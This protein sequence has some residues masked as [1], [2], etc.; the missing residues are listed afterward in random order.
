MGNEWGGDGSG[1]RI[2]CFPL[3]LGFAAGLF[4]LVWFTVR[5]IRG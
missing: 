2:P 1:S 4:G 3:V 5:S